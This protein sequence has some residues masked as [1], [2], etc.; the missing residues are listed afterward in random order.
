VAKMAGSAR[1]VARRV[2]VFIGMSPGCL[3]VNARF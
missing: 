3:R 2:S 1:A